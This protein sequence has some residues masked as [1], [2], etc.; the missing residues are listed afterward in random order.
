MQMFYLGTTRFNNATYQENMDYRTKNNESV[1]Y[2]TTIRTY[3]KYSYGALIFVIEMNNELNRIEGIS[4]IRN[5]LLTEKRHR[6]YS[7]GDYNRF[8]YHGDYWI[9][10]QQITDLDNELVEIFDLILF[11]GKSHL[12]RQSGISVITE[13]LFTNWRYELCDLKERVKQLFITIYKTNICLSL[14][15]DKTN[16][17]QIINN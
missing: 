12:K 10:R 8:I 14:K 9:N 11:K 5:I 3:K 13:K 2:G 7:N 15:D 1:I 6:I 4:L 16:N 17:E